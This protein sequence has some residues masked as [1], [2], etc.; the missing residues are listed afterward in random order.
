MPIRLRVLS[1]V[2]KIVKYDTY[3]TSPKLHDIDGIKP[4]ANTMCN[5]T[6]TMY[7]PQKTNVD[8]VS[9]SLGLETQTTPCI[10]NDD[11]PIYS[12]H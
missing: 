8:F 9:L 3:I 12:P 1:Y 11:V 4:V 7:N 2:T 10:H 6:L 5:D